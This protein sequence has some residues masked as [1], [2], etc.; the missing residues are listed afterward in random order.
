MSSFWCENNFFKSW[1]ESMPHPPPPIKA[2]VKTYLIL[3]RGEPS[4]IDVPRSSISDWGCKPKIFIN[5]PDIQILSGIWF[6]FSNYRVVT[7]YPAKALSRIWLIRYMW[8]PEYSISGYHGLELL[9][10]FYYYKDYDACILYW[11]EIK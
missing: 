11:K 9:E 6:I 7:G 1:I 2:M 8:H 10:T 3:T 5:L 4:V